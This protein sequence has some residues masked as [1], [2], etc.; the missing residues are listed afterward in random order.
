IFFFYEDDQENIVN[1]KGND[2]VE[3]ND[4]EDNIQLHILLK[5]QQYSNIQLELSTVDTNDF[6]TAV[7]HQPLKNGEKKAAK[8]PNPKSNKYTGMDKYRLIMLILGKLLKAAQ[9][10]RQ[11]S[12]QKCTAQRWWK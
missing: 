4:Q 10:G 11:L 1:E 7:N 2:P 3:T 8:S 9:A 12:I 6:V 5:L